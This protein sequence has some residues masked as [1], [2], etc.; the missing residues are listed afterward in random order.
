MRTFHFN[1]SH[2][3]PEIQVLSQVR[4]GNFILSSHV[5]KHNHPQNVKRAIY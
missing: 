5:R 3:V 2:C 1:V 4:T